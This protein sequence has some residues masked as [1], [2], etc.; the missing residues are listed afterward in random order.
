M[1]KPTLI[2]TGMLACLA[3]PALA[4]PLAVAQPLEVIE[5]STP[6]ASQEQT[7][8]SGQALSQP[9]SALCGPLAFSV[10]AAGHTV[11]RGMSVRGSRGDGLNRA[12]EL[13]QVLRDMGISAEI[14]CHFAQDTTEPTLIRTSLEIRLPAGL[15]AIERVDLRN[16]LA[17]L[18]NAR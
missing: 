11:V 10:T 9:Q 14:G 7:P 2:I 16:M 8:A 3:S 6:T 1:W 15:N 18:E 5:S 4:R 12:A 13:Y 17:A